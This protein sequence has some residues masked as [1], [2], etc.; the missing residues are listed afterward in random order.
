MMKLNVSGKAAKEPSNLKP[1]DLSNVW[2]AG[3]TVTALNKVGLEKRLTKIPSRGL[4]FNA[5]KV[6]ATALKL[7]TMFTIPSLAEPIKLTA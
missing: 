4:L 1:G 3:K 2:V 7:K 6:V 5:R